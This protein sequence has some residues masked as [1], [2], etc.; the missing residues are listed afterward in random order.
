MGLPRLGDMPSYE[1][2]TE[3]SKIGK[4]NPSPVFPSVQKSAIPAG[5]EWLPE[6]FDDFLRKLK[7]TVFKTALPFAQYPPF[8]HTDIDVKVT[9]AALAP[10]ATVTLTTITVP[11]NQVAVIR[12]YGQD[13]EAVVPPTLAAAWND[14]SWT[15]LRGNFALQYFDG[16]LGQRGSLLNL[17]PAAITIQG[18]DTFTV[19]VRNAG[20]V[21]YLVTLSLIGHQYSI[22]SM[23]APREDM[24]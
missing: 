2:P 20:A 13:V 16:F 11:Q 19:S 1:N 22:L 7:R 24:I 12:L 3:G 15:F 5:S 18:P 10:A 14:I 23:P 17:R 9:S 21:S 6:L 4:E 8:E